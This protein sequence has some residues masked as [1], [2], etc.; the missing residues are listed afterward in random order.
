[1]VGVKEDSDTGCGDPECSDEGNFVRIDHG[2]GTQGLYFHLERNG[3]QVAVGDG[4]CAG[5]VIGFSGNTG[6]STRSG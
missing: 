2:D 6:F 3:A 4:V 5:E 1:M